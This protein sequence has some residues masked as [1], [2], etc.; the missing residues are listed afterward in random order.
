MLALALC[1]GLSAPA[2]AA[3]SDFT[4]ENG[5]LKKYNG[6]G[7]SVTIPNGVTA[8]GDYAFERCNTVTSIIL[9]SSLTSIGSSAFARCANLTNINLP[10]S[11]T[12]I[13]SLAFEWCPNLTNVVIPGSVISVGDFAFNMCSKLSSVTLPDGLKSIGKKFFFV[14]KFNQCRSSKQCR[15]YR[16]KC[17]FEYWYYS[18]YNS[19]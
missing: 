10:N 15:I 1:M 13:G 17:F 11:I 6:S 5:V 12:Y 4:I 16:R 14:H 19:E 2:F 3:N 7:G 9:P 8:I 18:Y